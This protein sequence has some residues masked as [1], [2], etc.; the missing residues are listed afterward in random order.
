MLGLVDCRNHEFFKN[1]EQEVFRVARELLEREELYGSQM[2]FQYTPP[3]DPDAEFWTEVGGWVDLEAYFKLDEQAIRAFEDSALILAQAGLERSG[4]HHAIPASEMLAAG[5]E[6]KKRMEEQKDVVVRLLQEARRE[7]QEAQRAAVGAGKKVAVQEERIRDFLHDEER[8]RK[9]PEEDP[10]GEALE[11][12]RRRLFEARQ[13]A[14]HIEKLKCEAD[15]AASRASEKLAQAEI[16]ARELG[17]YTGE[18]PTVPAPGFEEAGRRDTVVDRARFFPELVPESPSSAPEDPFAGLM[19]GE[20]EEE[21]RGFRKGERGPTITG[22]VRELA[23]RPIPPQ[24]K[25]TTVQQVVPARSTT[26][27]FTQELRM[28]DDVGDFSKIKTV[29]HADDL[30]DALRSGLGEAQADLD[31]GGADADALARKRARVEKIE[32]N[33][34]TVEFVRDNL[35]AKRHR[36]IWGWTLSMGGLVVLGGLL[37]FLHRVSTMPVKS[38]V[39]VP[40]GGSV[41]KADMRIHLRVPLDDPDGG[42]EETPDMIR[43]PDL[44]QVPDMVVRPDLVVP[45]DL[46]PPADLMLPPLRTIADETASDDAG[47]E[48][49]KPEKKP[50][51]PR[52]VV[53]VVKPKIKPAVIPKAIVPKLT[54]R[55][56]LLPMQ[57]WTFAPWSDKGAGFTK[58]CRSDWVT[59]WYCPKGVHLKVIKLSDESLVMS[60]AI[61]GTTR[62]RCNKDPG[63]V[64]K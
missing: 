24:L 1:M 37:F 60:I 51:K 19:G 42:V 13:E 62:T 36:R 11:E 35:R 26:G 46:S 57:E 48:E 56:L 50:K 3:L 49:E 39:V 31:R 29:H 4:R 7:N 43:S 20:G 55:D 44:K 16:R 45:P 2:T 21:P 63:K 33:I 61:P 59:C 52:R 18:M 9:H 47:V 34:A 40:D 8:L 5:G 25:D 64:K 53:E 41:S 54:E 32:S 23:E 15:L 22:A 17:L 10:G 58:Y 30:I 12:I 6:E 38:H 28:L 27:Q 14:G